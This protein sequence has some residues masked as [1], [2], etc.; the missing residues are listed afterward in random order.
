RWC[1]QRQRADREEE[2]ETT[3]L[4]DRK[5]DIRTGDRV[6]RGADEIEEAYRRNARV[7]PGRIHSSAPQLGARD[8]AAR[9]IP[10][11]NRGD[12]D[13]ERAEGS[14]VEMA[15]RA[16]RSRE[17]PDRGRAC[18]ARGETQRHGERETNTEFHVSSRRKKADAATRRRSRGARGSLSDEKAPAHG[19]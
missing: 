18:R 12:I 5:G 16:V 14:S 10:G 1:G 6:D 15:I 7:V 19:G 9:H 2:H 4:A 13:V 11:Q 8:A 17:H 3:L